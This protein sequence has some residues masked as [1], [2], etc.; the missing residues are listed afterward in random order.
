MNVASAFSVR[1]LSVVVG[2]S[3]QDAHGLHALHAM[4]PE[5][6]RA[7]LETLPMGDIAALRAGALVGIDNVRVVARF[8]RDHGKKPMVVDPVFGATMGGTF[9]D[10][11]T[12]AAFRDDLATVGSVILTPNLEE[13]ARLLGRDR[14]ERSEIGDAAAELQARG[15]HAVL[16]KGGH[17][18]GDPIDALATAHGVHLY[19]DERM[20]GSMR[21][22]GCVLATALACELAHGLP[23]SDAVQAARTYVRSRIAMRIEFAGLQVAY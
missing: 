3:A 12:L 10:D 5:I 13:A 7:Q 11:A 16:V 6:V 14:I 4:S 17:L 1:M 22:T 18:A 23:L 15:A 2:V 9:V 8:A 21:G 19:T 20:K